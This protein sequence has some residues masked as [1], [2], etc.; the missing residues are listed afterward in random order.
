[1][2]N[3]MDKIISKN[4][5]TLEVLAELNKTPNE[6]L[7]D[8]FQN[9]RTAQ[10]HWS[11]VPLKKRAKKL[12]DLR[13]TLINHKDELVDLIVKENGKPQ[14]EAL[15]AEVYAC[16]EVLTY[17]AKKSPKAL[18]DKPLSISNPLLKHKKSYL[19]Y[20]P[21]GVVAI[22]SPWN[23]PLLLPF[24][25]IAMAI[26]SGNGVVF[27]PSEIT[28]LIGLKIQE[29]IEESG[30]PKNLVQ[31]VI[32][33]GATG[34]AI[35]EQKPNK[36]FFTGSV[37]TGK[38]IMAQASKTLTP[39]CLEL[40]G[41]D[42]MIVLPDANLEFAT[43]AA[44]WGGFSNSGQTCASTERLYLHDTIYEPFLEKLKTKIASLRQGR[45]QS[46][47]NNDLSVTT[48]PN[49]T[50]VYQEHLDDAKKKGAHFIHGGKLDKEANLMSP[51]IVAGD[52]IETCK[53]Y[54]EET[55]GPVIAVTKFKSVSEAIEK[56]NNSPYGLLASVITNNTSLGEEIAKQLE[57]G[58]V[59][60]NEVLYTA[61]VPETPW[62][63]VKNSGIGIKHSELGLHEFVQ[64]RHIHT[65]RFKNLLFKSFWWFPYS[66]FQTQTFSK[67]F[68][69]YR[70]SWIDKAKALPMFLWNVA[71]MIKKEPRI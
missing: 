1:M 69:L 42:A 2:L 36:I 51:T 27:K 3:N 28:P 56:A 52:S 68:E 65:N 62:G 25:E 23:Y 55:F 9:A 49:Q 44:L 32:G 61:G 17:I 10:A 21:V 63:G 70:K 19:N 39:V 34:A 18:R 41:K 8:I 12:L 46:A 64:V 4:P 35:I 31:T 48:D 45:T 33:D 11:Q 53:V 47:F 40:G 57:V 67:L 14:F 59:L 71:Q 29:L 16:V 13:E 20:W 66:N 26:T 38:K 58:S 15:V 43:S 37:A 60:V 5:A 50:T 24:S 54:Q 30:F 6:Q 7:N 22:I